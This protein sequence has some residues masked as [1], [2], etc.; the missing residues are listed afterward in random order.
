[1]AQPTGFREED[2]QFEDEPSAQ[3]ASGF[4]SKLAKAA[5][6]AFG[7]LKEP[8]GFSESEIQ[9]EDEGAAEPVISQEKLAKLEPADQALLASQFIKKNTLS[10]SDPFAALQKAVSRPDDEQV[11]EAR[12]QAL[13]LSKLK[14]PEPS[15]G[16][17]RNL[18]TEAETKQL[19]KEAEPAAR[20]GVQ[21]I[22]SAAFGRPVSEEEMADIELGHRRATREERIKRAQE[23]AERPEREARREKEARLAENIAAVLRGFSPV[24]ARISNE[25][26]TTTRKEGES[27]SFGP[28]GWHG[29]ASGALRGALGDT[30]LVRSFEEGG[31]LGNLGIPPDPDAPRPK[32]LPLIEDPARLSVE[33]AKQ[34]DNYKKNDDA[35]SH[36]RMYW[37]PIK[38][39]RERQGRPQSDE[40]LPNVVDLKGSVFDNLIDDPNGPFSSFS[41]AYASAFVPSAEYNPLLKRLSSGNLMPERFQE[42]FKGMEEER[43]K[44]RAR[45]IL[46]T[47]GNAARDF[48]DVVLSMAELGN[49]MFGI[50]KLEPG[51]TAEE[52]GQKTGYG[53]GMMPAQAGA[54]LLGLGD[55]NG[56]NS[57]LTHPF[58]TMLIGVDPALSVAQKLGLG[59]AALAINRKAIKLAEP[60]V[61]AA[62]KKYVSESNIR[63]ALKTKENIGEFVASLRRKMGEGLHQRDPRIAAILDAMIYKPEMVRERMK[64]VAEPLARQIG[65]GQV[66]FAPTEVEPIDLTATPAE[67]VRATQ[68]AEKVAEE[69]A[70]EAGKIGGRADMLRALRQSVAEGAKTVR[71]LKR[72]AVKVEEQIAKATTESEVL[73][74]KKKLAD[75]NN[76]QRIAN[77]RLA[78]EARRSRFRGRAE[79]IA[80]EAGEAGI[81][82]AEDVR[83]PDAERMGQ[84]RTEAKSLEEKIAVV[85]DETELGKLQSELSKVVDEQKKIRNRASA[86]ARFAKSRKNVSQVPF[87]VT[88]AMEAKLRDL[89][90]PQE[91]ID[92]T[93]P[94]EAW[95]II[96]NETKFE[97]YTPM[98]PEEI[99]QPSE[100][101]RLRGVKREAKVTDREIMRDMAEAER[102][103]A[104]ADEA[105]ERGIRVEDVLRERADRIRAKLE[106]RQRAR[107]GTA[108]SGGV[109]LAEGIKLLDEETTAGMAQEAAAAESRAAAG[110][111]RS[112]QAAAERAKVAGVRPEIEVGPVYVAPGRAAIGRLSEAELRTQLE[113]APD[114]ATKDAIRAELEARIAGREGPQVSQQELR[115]TA[116]QRSA[117]SDQLQDLAK[118]RGEV[119]LKD[120]QRFAKEEKALREKVEKA[121]NPEELEA[122]QAALDQRLAQSEQLATQWWQSMEDA[123]VSLDA[124]LKAQFEYRQTLNPN[125]EG[126]RREVRVIDSRAAQYLDR[127]LEEAKAQAQEAAAAFEAQISPDFEAFGKSSEY[128]RQKFQAL[129]DAA[130]ERVA[131]IE[132]AIEQNRTGSYR[133]L[134]R[135]QPQ[136]MAQAFEELPKHRRLEIEELNR[137]A[138]D[139]K[140]AA[141][142]AGFDPNKRIDI[143]QE[144]ADSLD[145]TTNPTIY[146][147]GR[148]YTEYVMN[149]NIDDLPSV[150]QAMLER[151]VGAKGAAEAAKWLDQEVQAYNATRYML[152]PQYGRVPRPA[153][154]E[155]TYQISP[156]GKRVEMPRSAELR[157][158]RVAKEKKEGI[159]E[160]SPHAE[161]SIQLEEEMADRRIPREEPVPFRTTNPLFEKGMRDI[162]QDLSQGA[163]EQPS[164]QAGFERAETPIREDLSQPQKFVQMADAE[165]IKVLTPERLAMRYTQ[166]LL[167]DSVQ[168]LRDKAYRNRLLQMFREKAEGAGLSESL[169]D[170]AVKDFNRLIEDPKLLT[171][172]GKNEFTVYRG[173]N[174]ETLWTREDF[175]KAAEKINP[176]VMNSARE[177][178]FR[179]VNDS[180]ADATRLYMIKQGIVDE[181]SR[182]Y[183]N[184]DGSLKTVLDAEGNE[185]PAIKNVVD[186]ANEL[187]KDT[188]QKGEVRPVF[189]PYGPN[190]IATELRNLAKKHPAEARK[191]EMLADQLESRMVKVSDYRGG[192]L[193]T[194]MDNMYREVFQNTQQPPW[195]RNLYVDR[196]VADSMIAHLTMLHDGST[197]NTAF[198]V[199]HEMSK[200]AK[201]SV[202]ANNVRSLVNN[203]LSNLLGQVFRRADP[204]MLFD[205]VNEPIKF[206]YYLDGDFSKLTPQEVRMFKSINETGM[207]NSGQVS[208]DIGQTNLWKT[209]EEAM[210]AK[211]EKLS[212]INAVSRS[213]GRD[214]AAPFEAYGKILDGLAEG[215]QKLGDV[216]FRLEEAVHVWKLD[217]AKTKALKPGEEN[218]FSVS[219]YRK[220]KVTMMEDGRVRIT[221]V[222]G[223]R[224]RMRTGEGVESKTY[225]LDSPELARVYAEHANYVQEKIFYDYGRVGNWAKYLRSSYFA[226]L[227][228]IFSWFFKAM[229]IPGIKKGYIS[230]LFNGNPVIESTSEAV[231][232][233]QANDRLMLS[234]RRAT[235]VSAATAAFKNQRELSEVRRAGGYNPLVDS[236]ILANATDPSYAYARDDA[237]LLFTQPTAN[238]LRSV[239]AIGNYF[240]F[241]PIKDDPQATLALMQSSEWEKFSPKDWESMRKNIEQLRLKVYAA[242]TKEKQEEARVELDTQQKMYEEGQRMLRIK[243]E[244]PDYYNALMAMRRDFMRYASDDVVSKEQLAQVFGLGGSPLVKWW[245][246]VVTNQNQRRWPQLKANFFTM[247]FGAAPW[248][249]ADVGLAALGSEESSYYRSM[250]RQGFA[251]AGGGEVLDESSALEW[252][253]RNL[254]GLGWSRVAFENTDSVDS[255]TEIKGRLEKRAET[256][257]KNL[258]SSLIK[259]DNKS[260]KIARDQSKTEEERAEAFR[261]I[262]YSAQI[263]NMIEKVKEET[264][265]NLER[266]FQSM[267]QNKK[268]NPN[269]PRKP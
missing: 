93:K 67:D 121:T 23:E 155:T 150:V 252:G 39:L 195:L 197:A 114:M 45:G 36:A 88:R 22:V 243:K 17:P 154:V 115:K 232:N 139:A 234:V 43:K 256:I 226:P 113:R 182:I 165:R 28:L 167:D 157:R 110:A 173:P 83:G 102:L 62:V 51:E 89:G 85:T 41:K 42:T 27:T 189:M 147:F 261:R 9:F 201:R 132:R 264:L 260:L 100:S 48:G 265:E 61:D 96:N 16:L 117:E 267:K 229:D 244:D 193:Q 240:E 7:K 68:A 111:Q 180:H 186:Y 188:V 95:D 21:D 44:N 209:V 217:E 145:L 6:Q 63:S 30:K 74:L 3:S 233:M 134:E 46:S 20:K 122:A 54:L 65:K 76:Q 237:P 40:G 119:A 227:S 184:P 196:A 32:E 255:D 245:E 151:R 99:P 52:H 248:S 116:E 172:H 176:Q 142:D 263:K 140:K 128:M 78:S 161:R 137:L 112:A 135:G 59:E 262:Q 130:N 1:M 98:K 131:K 58:S 238:V 97:D 212:D 53:L 218:V 158:E 148:R 136:T 153:S 82:L 258:T 268:N 2:I 71:D 225:G 215:Y 203:D 143:S 190:R 224:E 152:E 104:A 106:E 101:E 120:A 202:V 187:L 259:E 239:Q 80:Q 29:A 222:S 200:Y 249:V 168:L 207:V 138:S 73:E 19:E 269:P 50:T 160:Y 77:A 94:G 216:P 124:A 179:D 37:R 174:G 84:L 185:I 171:T 91:V 8:A 220:I 246:D 163:Y 254:F 156:E 251:G 213:K 183:R 230:E 175:A 164:L 66:K 5:T 129:V 219:P 55:F 60:V 47:A 210:G 126:I 11:E 236:V 15:Y 257:A 72:Q 133:V 75:L 90:F 13:S 69:A 18:K 162:Y 198:R 35:K 146:E 159:P 169:V 192:A 118:K 204:S 24:G 250:R 123:G 231:R 105:Q 166:A 208:K 81:E 86:E 57:M 194:A 199:F 108:A 4:A 177:R 10:F 206:K 228:G 12:R 211:A 87:M 127:L 223:A 64:A 25:P 92:R 79:K 170:A 214:L 247:V 109:R 181:N 242:K 149:R 49:E 107:A 34:W 205:I 31:A 178:A 125:L 103:H 26:L 253:I 221:E 141:L 38:A 33:R 144:L 56:T 241:A 235:L 70:T 191:L 14:G 266:D